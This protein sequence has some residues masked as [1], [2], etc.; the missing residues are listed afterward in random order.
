TRDRERWGLR[1]R[2]ET[3]EAL[4]RLGV[5]SSAVAFLGFHDQTLTDVVLARMRDGVQR[6]AAPLASFRPTLVVAPAMADRH[7]D[8]SALA[9]LMRLAL[10]RLANRAPTPAV[11]SYLV[12]P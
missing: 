5:P 12:H 4:R 9:V 3:A 7:P 10:A 8:H 1:R 2:G 6:L 11:V